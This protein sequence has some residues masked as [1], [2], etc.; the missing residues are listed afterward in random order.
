MN[1]A[2]IADTVDVLRARVRRAWADADPL[3]PGDLRQRL[4]DAE[5]AAVVPAVLTIY[6]HL[7]HHEQFRSAL[8]FLAHG[9]PVLAIDDPR[10][11]SVLRK[12][13]HL[14]LAFG[15]AEAER[16]RA[17]VEAVVRFSDDQ[18]RTTMLPPRAAYWTSVARLT[19]ARVA[20]EF[21]TDHGIHIFHA[22]A[23]FPLIRWVGV[24]PRDGVVTDG[25]AQAVRLGLPNAAFMLADDPAAIGI[26]DCVG[27]VDVLEHVLHREAVLDAAEKLCRPG[28]VVVV[29]TPHG[30]WMPTEDEHTAPL[31]HVG[32]QHLATLCISLAERGEVIHAQV[33]SGTFSEPAP[34]RTACV[35]YRPLVTGE[36]QTG[37]A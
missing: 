4:D 7:V 11:V 18:V 29:T 34:N 6:D 13:T 12:A 10:V 15:D 16:A 17:R 25:N 14:A 5:A 3:S 30:A 19:G 22:A 24:D 9:L 33:V 32:V 2:E 37:D 31:D 8:I 28:G 35:T 36:T 26:A 20:V 27:V 1:D 21:G 23:A